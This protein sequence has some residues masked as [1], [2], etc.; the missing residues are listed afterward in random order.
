[1]KTTMFQTCN[2]ILGIAVILLAI[3]QPSNAQDGRPPNP[4]H[5]MREGD[6]NPYQTNEGLWVM[7]VGASP[8]APAQAQAPVS[9]G[10]P[11]Q[12][13]YTWDDT[14]ALSWIDA[15]GGT[16]TGLSES[17]PAVGPIALPF[18][19]KYYE[20]AYSQVYASKHGYIGFANSNMT[21]S[22]GR[23]PNPATPNNLIAPYWTPT[24]L[25]NSGPT[26]RV[27]YA[28][29][30]APPNRYFVVE[31]YDVK[32]GA[33]SDA[34]GSDESYRF[35]ALLFENGD[36]VFQYQSMTYGGSYYCGIAGLED[37]AGQDG[38]VFASFCNGAPQSNKAVRMYRPG[39]SARVQISAINQDHLVRPGETMTAQITLR[40]TG[41]LGIDTYDFVTSSF[42][43]IS[44]Y[45]A[46]GT[47]LLSDTDLDGAI[48]SGTVSQGNS[49][50]VVA[51]IQVPAG[52]QVA[53]W[54][55]AAVTAR[56]SLNTAKLKTI[57]L[58]GAIPAPFAQVHRDDSDSAMSLYLAQPGAQAEKKATN[59]YWYGYNPAVAEA[60]DG[61]FVYVWT[62]GRCLTG[63]CSQYVNELEYAILNKYGETIRAVSRL[64][65]NSNATVNTYDSSPVVAVAPDGRVGILWYRQGTQP[66][67]G[68]YQY[69]YNVLFAALDASGSLAYGPVN[70]TNNSDWGAYN[71]PN[72]PQFYD[73][74]IAGTGDNRFALA[75]TRQVRVDGC[76]TNDCY[77]NDIYYAA[78]NS[79]G[80]EV[81]SVS[82]YTS[83]TTGNSWENYS[84][85]NLARLTGNRVLLCWS[86]GSNSD[87][88]YAVLD[89]NGNVVK[90]DT[91]L[92]LDG[93]VYERSPDAAQLSDGKTI[94]SW[95]ANSKIRFAVLDA[96]YNRIAWNEL[97]NPAAAS[98][99]SDYVS[100]AADN[101]GRAILTWMD[102]DYN[103]RRNLY[104]ALVNGGGTILTPPMIF[105]SSQASSPRIETSFV[106]YGVTSYSAAIPV[107]VDSAI[108]PDSALVGGLAG[109][110]TAIGVNFANHGQF[111]A[112]GIVMTATL[113]AGLAY[114]GDSSG[115]SP[116][117][118][119]QTVT[120]SLPD[121]AFLAKKRFTLFVGVPGVATIGNRYAVGLAITSSGLEANPSDNSATVEVMAAIQTYLPR[122]SR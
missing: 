58:Q 28:S 87:V 54:N 108:W 25:Q 114:Q 109:Q 23:I 53:D 46:N 14:I 63:N 72:V 103:S 93:S 2:R 41:D 21:A 13:G 43:P 1:M 88:Y 110:G 92:S 57:S 20:N 120:W 12:F 106:G 94:V 96:G 65:D 37:S 74:K 78:R 105:R 107:G 64:T 33:P 62:K 80:G 24:Y 68:T 4:P 98:S 118:D 113:A 86:R 84:T 117:V 67:S 66:I 34:I 51:K 5:L 70:L 52:T 42:W 6:G 18:S 29:G 59:A 49:V 102:Q 47:T 8:R 17:T 95:Y 31:W 121:L 119:G 3:S 104:Y 71:T 99:G 122:A 36:I 26:G 40:N 9:T 85:P 32:G 81:R 77:L 90:A 83:D 112:I 79:S 61:S 101:A 22:Q 7:P 48:D 115:V 11:D 16:D 56:S 35:E 15:T 73:A 75:W 30:G 50:N 60:P 76:V 19:F 55:A 39:P 38:L 100:V 116:V 89:S 97:P 44:L 69:N 82:Q 91:N 111:K 10:G 27:F 45:A